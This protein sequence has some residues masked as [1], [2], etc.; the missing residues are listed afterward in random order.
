MHAE[1]SVLMCGVAHA[2]WHRIMQ[3]VNCTLMH[4]CCTFFSLCVYDS[5]VR[6][7][8]SRCMQFK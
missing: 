5:V 2:C 3:S 1:N 4:V 8:I 6:N 7:S